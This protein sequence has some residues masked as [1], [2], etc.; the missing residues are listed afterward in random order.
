MIKP[1]LITIGIILSVGILFGPMVSA[2][3]LVGNLIGCLIFGLFMNISGASFYNAKKGIEAG[4]FG[5]K[6]STAHKSAIIG[7]TVGD[8]LKDT[9]GPNMSILITTN[10]TLT[11]TFLPIFIMTAFL[12]NI[13]SF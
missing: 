5:G 12:W 6:G 10:N 2:A 11:I 1:V 3:V 4:L 9:A 8:A 7:D 13:F